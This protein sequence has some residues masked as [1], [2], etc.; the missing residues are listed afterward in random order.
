MIECRGSRHG[1]RCL[2]SQRSETK[3]RELQIVFFY[4]PDT[5]RVPETHYVLH[6]TLFSSLD[7]RVKYHVLP[8]V[9]MITRMEGKTLDELF[10]N[11]KFKPFKAPE[12]HIRDAVGH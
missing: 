7:Y 12:I 9:G 10:A 11:Y 3:A 6:S 2:K 4:F 1:I 8:I 5:C